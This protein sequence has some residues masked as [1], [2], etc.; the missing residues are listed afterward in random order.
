MCLLG[1]GS[2]S[3]ALDPLKMTLHVLITD[4]IVTHDTSMKCCMGTV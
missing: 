2:S 4:V 1:R 3:I